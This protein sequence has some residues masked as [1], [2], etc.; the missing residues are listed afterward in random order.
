MD[1]KRVLHDVL[2]ADGAAW[3]KIVH[4][5]CYPKFSNTGDF[6]NLFYR[7]CFIILIILLCPALLSSQKLFI[8]N[9]TSAEGLAQNQVFSV[10]QDH[11][12]FMWFGT[13]G[14]LSRYDGRT[15]RNYTKENGLASNVIR[16]IFESS[17]HRLWL[18]T[19][20][21]LS[22]YVIKSDSFVNYNSSNELYTGV[23][24]KGTVRSILED[25]SGNVWFATADGLSVLDKKTGTFYNF[26][27]ADGLPSNVILCL[28]KNP[29]NTIYAGTPEG[30]G[31]VRLKNDFTIDVNRISARD[32]LINNRIEAIFY[33]TFNRLWIGTPV[34]VTKIE[35]NKFR[36]LTSSS[37]LAHNSVRGITQSKRG[38]VWIT[39][40]GGISFTDSRSDPITFKNYNTK[41]GFAGNFFYTMLED[42]ENNF[43]FG[44]FGK[45]V[46]KLISEE[47]VSYLE[48]D[49]LIND[50]I[51]SAA[52]DVSG[53]LYIGTT[54]GLS[55]FYQNKFQSYSQAEGLNA[56]EI[57]DVT[58]D[59]QGFIWLG[60]Y[61]GLK[62]LIP[63]NY[64]SLYP[65]ISAAES[66]KARNLISQ[67]QK[68]KDFYSVNL[69]SFPELNGR[70]VVDIVVDSR[71][72]IWF[73]S[74]DQGIGYI[75]IKNQGTLSV[76]LFTTHHGLF[77]NNPWCLYEDS[78][79]RMW[80]GMI[81]GGLALFDETNESF[82]KFTQK[83]GLADDVA[84]AL[85]EDGFGN[86]W[87]GSERGITRLD[88]QKLPTPSA[89]NTDLHAIVKHFSTKDGLTDN[90]VNAI[91]RDLNGML[92]VGT[93]N[94]LNVINPS[95]ERIVKT[96]TK[97][98]GLIDHE[99]STNNSLITDNNFV[100]IGTA[101][102]LTRLPVIPSVTMTIPA[103][104]VYLTD[105]IVEDKTQKQT[106]RLNVNYRQSE[107]ATPGDTSFFE[108]LFHTSDQTVLYEE[109]NI[110]ID[111]VSPS[112][113]DENDVRY[114]YRLIGFEKEW[115]E[116]TLDNRVRYTNLNEGNYQFEVMAG[117]GLG[118]WSDKPISVHFKILTPFWKSWW[119]IL[120]V[121]SFVSLGVYTLYQFRISLVRQ[122]TAELEAK[123][124][125]R[126]RELMVQKETVERILNELRETQMHLVHSEKMASLG[127]MVAGIA[128]EINNPITY[129]K[130]NIS[131]LEKKQ[132][133]V[134][135]MFYSFSD[136]FDFFDTFKNIHDEPHAAFAAKMTEI[137]KLIESSKF[138]KFLSDFPKIIH[139]MRDGVERTQKIVED[140]RNFSRLDE[141]HFKEISLIDSIESTLNI[142]KNEY[143]NRIT[144][145]RNFTELPLIYCNPGH[146]NQV[147]MNLLVNAFQ[148]IEGEG[149]VWIRTNAGQNNILITIKDNGKGIPYEIQHKVYD[150][151]FTT[152]PV[153]KGTGLGLAISYKI[154][155]A[156]KGTIFFESAPGVGTEFKITLPI[157]KYSA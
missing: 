129:V 41:N 61:N 131:L 6:V 98:Q 94:G 154:L 37:G 135:A 17:D 36:N 121:T 65:N 99:V 45:G 128:H 77:N 144:I 12:G 147:L 75:T 74:T 107:E 86:L 54:I 90:C 8:K 120:F 29:E 67:S 123:V 81:G 20:E 73:A 28:T 40:E 51:L 119:F 42:R 157:R 148:S 10:E 49:G 115:S 3:K 18:G 48:A 105:F 138:E 35:D 93:N 114:R 139:E 118:M 150:P 58:I 108:R 88:I 76:K 60:T 156:H 149:D 146:I 117:N 97:R 133:Q 16:V 46:S 89:E 24:G 100:W 47:L 95:S 55:I 30:I 104:V 143:K 132:H 64:F 57:W 59:P 102:G 101:G 43:W 155:E 80:A 136:L 25:S 66:E 106:R 5:P 22:R 19:D 151:F 15:F 11:L 14:G 125:K 13:G 79:H 122:R 7:I 134:Q 110:M 91:T 56:T 32:G 124:A 130:A 152:K 39:T 1:A 140:L 127:Q 2:N 27:V 44:T 111:F 34:G 96:Y 9:Y 153:G 33:D 83:D 113:K 68:I 71:Q 142:L 109:N 4:H 69:S 84:L 23:L 31:V 112:F 141:S 21:G 78:Q 116:P 50:A 145:H 85:C 82:Y 53:R 62:L 103:P 26:T 52:H 63:D 92:W 137:D 87:I 38:Y 70:R 72:R 126:T